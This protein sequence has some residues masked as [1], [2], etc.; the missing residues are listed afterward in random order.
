MPGVFLRV[1]K[2]LYPAYQR[3]LRDRGDSMPQ[4]RFR[5][6]M[7]A[8]KKRG[9]RTITAGAPAMLGLLAQLTEPQRRE[10]IS[11][12]NETL[13]PHFDDT[14]LAFPQPAHV[15]SARK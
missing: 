15:A 14:G 4:F 2:G 12:I 10:L 1:L 11:E 8:L 6:Q 7:L 9:Y 5:E 3:L 13:A